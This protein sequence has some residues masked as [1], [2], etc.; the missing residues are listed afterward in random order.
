MIEALTWWNAGKSS[1]NRGGEEEKKVSYY[2]LE[3][4]WGERERH[5]LCSSYRTALA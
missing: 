2:G 4:I 5:E 1:R 3:E